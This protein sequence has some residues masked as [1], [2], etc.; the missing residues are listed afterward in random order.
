MIRKKKTEQNK[1]KMKE[2]IEENWSEKKMGKIE[3]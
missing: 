1:Q 3:Q 2:K